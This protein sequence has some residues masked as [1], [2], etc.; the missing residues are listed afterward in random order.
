M[1]VGD[2]V[3]DGTQFGV[4]IEKED[5]ARDF[6]AG[7]RILW[8]SGEIEIAYEEEGQVVSFHVKQRECKV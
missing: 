6:P 2:L 7:F 4:V 3:K 8:D 1:K 5:G